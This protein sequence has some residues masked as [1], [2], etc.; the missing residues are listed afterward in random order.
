MEKARKSIF[1]HYYEFIIYCMYIFFH[2]YLF[3][4]LWKKNS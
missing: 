2:F 1:Q 3:L 4:L